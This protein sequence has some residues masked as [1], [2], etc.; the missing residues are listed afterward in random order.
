M[1]LAEYGADLGTANLSLAH[2]GGG[3]VQR[4]PNLLVMNE[5][6]GEARRWRCWTARPPGCGCTGRWK[7][8][9]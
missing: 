8:A 2:G 1:F 9:W 4:E 3:P 7:R 6:R 5:R